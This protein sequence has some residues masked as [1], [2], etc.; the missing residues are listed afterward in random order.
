MVKTISKNDFN[1]ILS[2]GEQLYKENLENPEKFLKKLF[3]EKNIS[4]TI[5]RKA[6]WGYIIFSKLGVKN[7]LEEEELEY[8]MNNFREKSVFSYVKLFKI[9]D[10]EKLDENSKDELATFFIKTFRLKEK[11]L[12]E[13]IESKIQ[14]IFNEKI[15]LE[16]EN[17]ALNERINFL[18]NEI[19]ILKKKP[20]KQKMFDDLYTE[21]ED[22]IEKK[23]F[24]TNS[25]LKNEINYIKEELMEDINKSLLKIT[26]III[27]IV[28]LV[29]IF[30]K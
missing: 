9:F 2:L 30:T 22:M 10:F 26:F 28:S 12:N 16:K 27:S 29:T 19:K 17:N 13:A 21:I 11:E 14:N 15:E 25:E 18:S 20:S 23:L 8:L 5:G 4:E 24:D 6:Y 7:K 1:E 3:K